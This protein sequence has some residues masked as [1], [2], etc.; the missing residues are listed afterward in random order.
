M[1]ITTDPIPCLRAGYVQVLDRMG[2]DAAVVAAARFSVGTARPAQ[3]DRGLI[4]YLVRNRHTTP[5]ER[6]RIVLRV[7]APIY[8]ARQWMRHRTWTYNEIS[9]RYTELPAD[10]DIPA[11]L[12]A[13]SESNR[14]GRGDALDAPDLRELLGESC[15]ASQAVY[16]ALLDA[17]VAREQ[18]RAVL[19][20]ATYTEF[21]AGV[22]L[23][24]L[25]HFLSLRLH[26]HAQEEI[27]VYAEAIAG[28]VRAWVPLVWEAFEDYTLGA[29]LLSRQEVQAMQAML[30]GQTPDLTGLSARERAAFE[31]KWGR[32]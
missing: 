2:D 3:S 5:L 16:R 14:Q 26:P 20:V 18:A 4:R 13:Q 29:T 6:C 25:L 21:V 19:P 24:N 30:R 23:H 8:V 9:A 22:D 15:A 1:T 17:G 12:H 7:R 28:I 10:A 32:R 27:R 31:E 11:A